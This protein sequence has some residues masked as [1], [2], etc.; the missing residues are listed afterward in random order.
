MVLLLF[1][2]NKAY[3]DPF[4]NER[5][6]TFFIMGTFHFEPFNFFEKIISFRTIVRDWKIKRQFKKFH[7]ELFFY[8]SKWEFF[9]F[10]LKTEIERFEM[11]RGLYNKSKI[12]I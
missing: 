11:V 7:F 10:F 12:E 2:I 8:S 3:Y 6:N 5:S 1:H 4:L 9:N